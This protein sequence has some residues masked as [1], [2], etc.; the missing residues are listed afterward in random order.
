MEDL[1]LAAG[2]ME[3]QVQAEAGIMIKAVP[4]SD[5]TRQAPMGETKGD[6]NEEEMATSQ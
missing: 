5:E 1:E 2:Q 6:Q 4:T 3:E